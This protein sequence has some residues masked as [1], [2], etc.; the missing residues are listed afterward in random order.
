MRKCKY[1][2]DP[3]DEYCK[4]CNGCTMTNSKNEEIP[5]TECTGYEAGEEV[6]EEEKKPETIAEMVENP[7][8]L[9][10]EAPREENKYVYAKKEEKPSESEF[11]DKPALVENN[12]YR[13]KSI[14]YSSG[15]T[16]SR[17]EVYYKIHAEEEWEL[18]EGATEAEIEDAQ[19]KLWA[20]VNSMVD[21]QVDDI[22]CMYAESGDKPKA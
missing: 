8:N 14:R 22:N 19:E 10:D 3:E 11:A 12:A 21:A 6:K 15:V 4:N 18:K 2:G 9:A 16:F 7:S 5:C 17:N 1:A 20:K 13:V